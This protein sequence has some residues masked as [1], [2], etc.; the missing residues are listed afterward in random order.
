MQAQGEFALVKEK[1][2]SALHLSGQPVKRGTMAHKHIIYMMLTEAAARLQDREA[3]PHYA[4]LLEELAV[5]DGHQPYLAVAHRAWGVAQRLNEA[6]AEADEH[7]LQ[8]LAV[9]EERGAHWQSGRTRIELGEL[10]LAQGDEAQARGYLAQALEAFERVNA[11]P[12]VER[13]RAALER[14]GSS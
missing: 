1:L 4:S 6:Y 2:E 5:R 14:L 7:L 12:D 8:A 10:A 9:F 11:R 13:T 3:L